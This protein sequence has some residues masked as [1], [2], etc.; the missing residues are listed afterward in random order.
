MPS[1]R[2]RAYQC[3][4]FF[5]SRISSFD[6]KFQQAAVLGDVTLFFLREL[7]TAGASGSP[8]EFQ[9]YNS[10][11]PDNWDCPTHH[12]FLKDFREKRRQKNKWYNFSGSNSKRKVVPAERSIHRVARE[13]RLKRGRQNY[14]WWDW[15]SQSRTELRGERA[16]ERDR[17]E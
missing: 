1:T 14:R 7:I 8:K 12:G 3:T 13:E 11:C 9:R 10:K 2:G 5:L 15:N 6:T 16:R 17:K 4:M